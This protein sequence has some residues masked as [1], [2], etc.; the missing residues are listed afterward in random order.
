MLFR[1]VWL[2]NVIAPGAG[3]TIL[4][5]LFASSAYVVW[6]LASNGRYFARE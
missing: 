3:R 6:A 2:V 5:L 1:S 4:L